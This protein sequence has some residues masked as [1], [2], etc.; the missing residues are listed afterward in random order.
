MHVI[1]H[2]PVSHHGRP[3]VILLQRL[4]KPPNLR[5]SVSITSPICLRSDPEGRR[6]IRGS[7]MLS[8][9]GKVRPNGWRL[10]P[11]AT[12]VERPTLNRTTHPTINQTPEADD[13]TVAIRNERTSGGQATGADRRTR[14]R[15]GG[16]RRRHARGPAEPDERGGGGGG[17][18]CACARSVSFVVPRSEPRR[19]SGGPRGAGAGAGGAPP[20]EVPVAC[21]G[22]GP[23]RGLGVRV[24]MT[25][26]GAACS[27]LWPTWLGAF[28]SNQHRSRGRRPAIGHQGAAR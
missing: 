9:F 24:R 1:F 13:R 5:H 14:M 6:T 3:S 22:G 2:L 7:R 18:S 15:R 25:H 4:P 17:G 8:A 21:G 26:D 28:P 23:L 20:G 19:G 10:R 12:P 16:G 27:G 11:E